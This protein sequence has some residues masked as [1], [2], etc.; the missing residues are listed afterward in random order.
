MPLYFFWTA[1]FA[2]S[3]ACAVVP[4]FGVDLQELMKFEAGAI[5][6]LVDHAVTY[7]S[8]NGAPRAAQDS[9]EL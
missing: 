1:N 5:P 2:A 8:S 3:L 7:L 9:V 6:W 4:Y